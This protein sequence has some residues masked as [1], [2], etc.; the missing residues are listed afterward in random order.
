MA[1]GTGAKSGRI[2]RIG[3][4]NDPAIDLAAPRLFTFDKL[5]TFSSVGGAIEFASTPLVGLPLGH[6]IVFGGFLHLDVFE[7]TPQAN[8]VDTF[9]VTASLG[10]TATA[11]NALATTEINLLTAA[12]AGV[13]VGGVSPHIARAFDGINTVAGALAAAAGTFANPTGTL[14]CFLNM[15]IPDADVS[16]VATVRVRGSV[17]IAACGLG[18]NS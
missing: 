4:G 13:A 1:T 7:N 10:T 2:D 15:T 9:N 5:V 14:A 17:R 11:D 3:Q 12:A 8:L 18:K 6:F 16:G